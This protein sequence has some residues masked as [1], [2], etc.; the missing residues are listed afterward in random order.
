MIKLASF[1]VILGLTVFN[2]F[3]INKSNGIVNAQSSSDT[4][5]ASQPSQNTSYNSNIDELIA[6]RMAQY[7]TLRNTS[8]TT[9]STSTTAL[10]P[11]PAVPTTS[12]APSP[13]S[14][15]QSDTVAN[16][17]LPAT[18]IPSEPD[19]PTQTPSQIQPRNSSENQAENTINDNE[20]PP[21]LASAQNPTRAFN[22]HPTLQSVTSDQ[23][24][25][26][27]NKG[28]KR[29]G[30]INL[31]KLF[32]IAGLIYIVLMLIK[33]I[34]LYLKTFLTY[35]EAKKL[36]GQMQT[37]QAIDD[38]SSS[39]RHIWAPQG[40][41]L[42]GMLVPPLRLISPGK[43]ELQKNMHPATDF[44]LPRTTYF[45]DYQLAFTRNLAYPLS[46]RASF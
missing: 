10:T 39:N 24:P 40:S 11:E 43:P 1:I 28:Q 4:Q 45:T 13:T 30:F 9:P 16:P 46:K 41:E 3:A 32:V 34:K 18:A 17:S 27:I 2:T 26:E 29:A 8:T 44:T 42:A 36:N 21:L 23:K 22:Q 33:K 12:H 37:S 25:M 5:S 20:E 38:T 35:I 15:D 14:S 19:T 6:Q 31:K 7:S